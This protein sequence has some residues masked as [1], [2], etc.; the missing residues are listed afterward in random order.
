MGDGGMRMGGDEVKRRGRVSR[1]GFGC[2]A[3]AAQ[4]FGKSPRPDGADLAQHV[5]DALLFSRVHVGDRTSRL[6]DLANQL[7]RAAL[8][9]LMFGRMSH[10][11]PLWTTCFGAF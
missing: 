5:G 11:S 10:D 6:E 2:R 4:T 8:D 9:R 3:I 1:G 7:G